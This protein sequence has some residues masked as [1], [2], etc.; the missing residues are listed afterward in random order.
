MARA[1]SVKTQR[2][3]H[4][5]KNGR[6][7]ASAPADPASRSRT[8][9]LPLGAGHRI[10]CV[11]L[12]SMMLLLLLSGTVFSQHAKPCGPN[13]G[14][15][16]VT[17][18]DGSQ[19]PYFGMP[20]TAANSTPDP[21][22]GDCFLHQTCVCTQKCCAPRPGP[23]GYAC[24]PNGT[25]LLGEVCLDKDVGGNK[26]LAE[27]AALC[28]AA[29]HA[30]AGGTT[31]GCQGFNNNGYLK[32]CVRPSC[33]AHPGPVPGHPLLVSCVSV[34][35]PVSQP[36]PSGADPTCR[37]AG[38]PP[39]PGPGTFVPPYGGGC[40]G[41]WNKSSCNCAGVRPP[42]GAPEHA[43]PIQHDYHFP[44]DE[45][46]QRASLPDIQLLSA[47]VA[48]SAVLHNPST[49]ESAT[50]TVGGTPKWGW[51]LLHVEG[52][53]DSVVLEHDFAEWS[54]LRYLW[55]A[56]AAK[57]RSSVSVRKPV[58][59][60]A[61]ISQPLYAMET[62]IDPQYH[63]KQD[64]DPFDWMGRLAA[65]ISGG[66]EATIA[67]ANTL[68]A[69][70]TDSG[71]FG[72]PEDRNKFM[73]THRS[74]LQSTGDFAHPKSGSRTLWSLSDS[75][76][77]LPPGCQSVK[78]W[79]QVK[80]G[81]V[82]DHFRALNQGM[83][84]PSG[85]DDTGGPAGGCG[86]EI[87]AVSPPA[88][89]GP[90][91]NF[92]GN[93]TALLRVT[94]SQAGMQTNTSYLRVQ[95]S[96]DGAGPLQLDELS[97]NQGGAQFYAALL[98]QADRWGAFIERGAKAAVPEEDRRYVASSNALMTMFM[99]TDR[100]LIPIYGGG[101]C[102]GNRLPVSSSSFLVNLLLSVSRSH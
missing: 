51:E 25:D 62:T 78:D 59:E 37:H 75:P 38:P 21:G 69:P 19:Y 10:S 61:G 2:F 3:H 58:G 66:E 32:K 98:A 44:M 8:R 67:S 43:V 53:G 93:T 83:W 73:L 48:G 17:R 7:G 68:M 95:I 18:A 55:T 101:Q 14:G 74:V 96:D 52:S 87:M 84:Q 22:C 92:T 12:A 90:G 27:I 4:S 64:I 36:Y 57:G 45:P 11:A 88:I 77:H 100:G 49:K 28:D 33:G 47:S 89:A 50:L 71:I 29:R 60:L 80:M 9:A 15:Q 20:C 81:M 24:L 42:F 34:D 39:P 65:N 30:G 85:A 70:N 76:Q 1:H 31:E 46:A 82:G 35:T 99:N 94:S 79:A 102:V 6:S 72:N 16:M 41:T 54:E 97:G 23:P 26:S 91:G 63:C 13:P 40:A 56:A 86:V 5:R